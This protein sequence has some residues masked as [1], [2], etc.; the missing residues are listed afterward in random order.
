MAARP[1]GIEHS[2]AHVKP[3]RALNHPAAA[4][5]RGLPDLILG[6][7]GR[8]ATSTNDSLSDEA[9]SLTEKSLAARRPEARR[10]VALIVIT[11]ATSIALGVALRQ[12]TF[13]GANDISRW[14]TVWSLLERGTYAI[15]ECPWQVE[16][17]DKVF[18]APRQPPA[19][20]MES[21]PVRHYYSSK[22]A[23]LPTLIAGILYPARMATG[24]PLDHVVYQERAERWTQQPD[25]GSP[26]KVK[27]VLEKPSEPVKWPAYIF[28]FK[29]ITILFNVVPFWVFLV[30]FARVLDRHAKNDWAWFFSLA[31]AA[32]GTYLLAFT[33]TLNNHTIAAFSAFFAIYQFLAI[34]DDDNRA[35]WRFALAGLCAGFA[36]ANELPALAFLALLACLLV[37]RFFGRTLLF[38][39][40]AA[41]IPLAAF[42]IAQ[43]AVFGEFKLA[44]E[45]FGTDEYLYEGSLWKTPLDLD[46]LN[47]HPEP[48][49]I[50][51]LHMT[52]GHHGFFSLSPIFLFSCWGALRLLGPPS[53]SL[54]ALSWLTFLVFVGLAGYY[55]H[56]P[57][58]WR[59][60]G[61]LAFYRWALYAVLAFAA[62]AAALVLARR[63]GE[64]L[65]A[66]AWLTA[67][68]TVVILAFYTGNP[69]ARNYGG[70]TQGLRW[71]FWLIPFWLLLLIKG[72][73]AGHER[74][75][76]RVL[77][78]L[79]LGVSAVSVGYA[80]RNPWSHPWILDALVHLGLYP[81]AV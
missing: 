44:Y 58:A 80:M 75:V 68:L 30:L 69:L 77:A 71:L 61:P 23:L 47:E 36:A 33:Q 63:A 18:R 49:A 42:A 79:A 20:S 25:P 9:D 56:D 65:V 15:D 19:T 52:L 24:V 46:A 7:H 74:P 35:G 21:E 66:L 54:T 51:L 31:A 40:P 76:V 16:T 3:A 12:P 60:Q 26:Y 32:F 45:S 81:L 6:F 37:V 14:C 10:F 78:L 48:Q 73:E 17:Q 39:V 11:A 41:A 55:L 38:F 8:L 67:A 27:G 72:V 57:A 50:Y 28:Y 5:T 43:Y 53:Q 64:P 34:W 70:S 59:T 29:P 62:I 22:P 2:P 13:M 4:L 1:W